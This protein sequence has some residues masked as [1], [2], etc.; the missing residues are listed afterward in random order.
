MVPLCVGAPVVNQ[1]QAKAEQVKEMFSAI[2]H[3]YDLINSLL[4]LGLD[5]WWRSQAVKVA[6]VGSPSNLL[7][8]ATGTGDLALAVKRHD[9]RVDVVGLDLSDSMLAI[10]RRKANLQGLQ[11]TWEVGN[12][13]ELS[14]VDATFGA[15]TVAY[16]LRN[17]ENV[18]KCLSEFLRLLTPGGRLVILEFT[19]PSSD[20]LGT[21]ASLYSSEIVP[22]VGGIISGNRRAYEYLPASI[23]E[24]VKPSILGQHMELAGF[25]NV[26][27]WRQFP[28]VSAVHL[29]V[30]PK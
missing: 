26:Q 7:D 25:C 29:G 24:F 14:F 12:A 22:A 6:L 17:F 8:I 27:Y 3:R 23:K 5:K 15:I 20:V 10:A 16:G 21:L 28:G 30:K 9:P 4:S 1:S 19:P 11:I 18:D 13:S 2:A